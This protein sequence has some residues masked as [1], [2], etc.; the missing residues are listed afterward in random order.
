[1]KLNGKEVVIKTP[2][3][4]IRHKIGFITEDRK[5]TGLIVDFKIGFNIALPISKLVS[6]MGIMDRGKEREFADSQITSLKIKASGAD[7]AVNNLSGGN[8]QKVVIGKWLTTRPDI[9]VMDEPTRGVD[10]G[11]KSEIYQIMRQLADSG[12]G[13]IMIS[14]DLPEVIGMS[15]TIA[16]MHEGKICAHIKKGDATE[17]NIMSYATGIESAH[18]RGEVNANE[19]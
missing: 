12:V 18:N 9:L 15:D 2:K 10:V 13:I 17:Q 19:Q 4:S 14:S 7:M 1:V 6:R 11:A 16:V 8:Q 5:N 3:D